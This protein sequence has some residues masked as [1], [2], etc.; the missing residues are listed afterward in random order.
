MA[1]T[2]LVLYTG[3]HLIIG[4]VDP[5]RRRLSDHLNDPQRAYLEVVQAQRYNLMAETGPP[6]M[7]PLLT[8]RKERV[9]IAIPQDVGV[10]GTARAPTQ[11]L[12]LE[13]GFA[14]FLVRGGVH[15][16]SSDPTSPL[17]LFANGG[18]QF[19]PVSQAALHYLPNNRFDTQETV[20]LVNV[21]YLDF[22]AVIPTAQQAA[23]G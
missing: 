13:L 6:G 3:A 15:R 21:H 17:H 7:A 18:R 1:E 2:G 20:A 14:L 8:L 5:G 10:P 11:Q 12:P 23:A 19:L 16:R 4:Q 9:Q 22:W